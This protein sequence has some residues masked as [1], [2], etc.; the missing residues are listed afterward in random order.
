[1]A[2]IVHFDRHHNSQMD[3]Y[4]CYLGL[5]QAERK[6]IACKQVNLSSQHTWLG[7]ERTTL[8]IRYRNREKDK[9]IVETKFSVAMMVSK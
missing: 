5:S 4:S 8:N 3:K 1:M 9:H 2:D 6:C 7:K